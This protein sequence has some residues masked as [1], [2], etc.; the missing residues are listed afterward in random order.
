M[1]VHF[2]Q[3]Y[4]EP[5]V[6]FPFS[7]LF[8][9]RLSEEIT[10]LITPSAAFTQRYGD[11]WKLMFNVS[12]KRTIADNEIRGPSVFKKDKDVEFTIFLPFDTIQREASVSRCALAF[13][14]QGV[15]SVLVSLGIDTSAIQ[16]RQSS[17]T[18]TISSDP[19]MFKANDRN[20]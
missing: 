5:G 13:L 14:L 2:G 12:A 1:K 6:A 4:I 9:R 7:F 19:T 17:L 20:A 16:V 18:E 15:C 10:A 8:Q 3:I 11:D